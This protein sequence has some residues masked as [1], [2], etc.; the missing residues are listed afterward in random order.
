M[1]PKESNDQPQSENPN[2]EEKSEEFK[3]FEAGMK[4]ILGLKRKDVERIKREIPTT[5]E[6][7]EDPSQE[8]S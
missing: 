2:G 5:N 8:N 7:S 6:S 3:N 1:Q 4:K